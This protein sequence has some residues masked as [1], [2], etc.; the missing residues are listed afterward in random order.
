MGDLMGYY[1]ITPYADGSGVQVFNTY[2]SA[3]FA[4]IEACKSLGVDVP[5]VKIEKIGAAKFIEPMLE[6]YE[7]EKAP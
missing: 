3:V 5:I 1:G 2:E 4:A 7:A 6:L